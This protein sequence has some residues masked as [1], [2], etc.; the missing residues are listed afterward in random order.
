MPLPS[1]GFGGASVSATSTSPFGST[2]TERGC[3]SP[4]ANR[5]TFKPFAAVGFA[6]SGQPLT[7]A[8]STVGISD[9]RG[10]GMAGSGPVPADTGNFAMSPQPASVARPI[11]ASV[12]HSNRPRAK[13]NAPNDL[14][15]ANP[16][17]AFITENHDDS[18]WI[19]H[20]KR[21]SPRPIVA[22]V[23]HTGQ[24]GILGLVV[25]IAKRHKML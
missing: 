22:K 6:F 9:C 23:C 18:S 19:R 16:T 21:S 20:H 13:A 5:S 17:H 14:Q 25:L 8:M 12:A 2:Y 4:F 1:S 10:W 24:P 15:P 11:A 3:W 7:G